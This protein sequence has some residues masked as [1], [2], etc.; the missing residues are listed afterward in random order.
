LSNDGQH[1]AF[2]G[3]LSNGMQH[4]VFNGVAGQTFNAISQLQLSS[5]GLHSAFVG[6]TVNNTGGASTMIVFVDGSNKGT[7]NNN[8]LDLQVT[9]DGHFAFVGVSSN[10]GQFTFAAN[11]NGT[12]VGTSGQI[13]G[14]QLSADGL[15]FGFITTLA[16]GTQEV[17][18]NGRIVGTF[19]PTGTIP[20][21][22]IYNLQL[23][24]DGQHFAYEDFTD[25]SFSS[26]GFIGF[27][28]GSTSAAVIL[29]GRQ[30]AS[31]QNEPFFIEE[32][33]SFSA[34]DAFSFAVSGGTLSDGTTDFIETVPGP[35]PVATNLSFLTGPPSTLVAGSPFSTTVQV[36]DQ[37]GNPAA[38]TTVRL[39]VSSGVLKGT[40]TATTNALGQAVFTNLSENVAGTFS[41]LASVTGMTAVPSHSFTVTPGTASRLSFVTQPQSTTAG[42]TFNPVAVQVVDQF[43]NAVAKPGVTVSLRISSGTLQ[44]S[45]TATTNAQGQ[46]VFTNLS[47]NTAGTYLLRASAFGLNGTATGLFVIRPASATA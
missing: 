15:H 31:F 41:L 29:D 35:A 32:G 34:T 3:T 8:V 39:G 18:V 27:P 13:G 43:G 1:S 10:A 11:V 25:N 28:I 16:N 5:N 45:L 21:S 23:S 17:I 9:G 7:F 6:V 14:L 4:A 46:A 12:I 26:I 37:F 42:S 19:T 20:V 40:L 36:L 30:I 24:P 44:G 22:G 33:H 2:I 38:G 47:D